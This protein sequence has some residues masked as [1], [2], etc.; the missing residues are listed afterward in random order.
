MSPNDQLTA[1]YPAY[2]RQLIGRSTAVAVAAYVL[3]LG[4]T[5]N[6]VVLARIQQFSLFL[7]T[8][9]VAGWLFV[10]WRQRD[11]LPCSSLDPA[12]FGWGVAFAVSGGANISGRVLVGVWWALLYLGVWWVLSDLRRRGMPGRWITD[13]V[14]IAL[15]P[16]LLLAVV[17]VALW[18]PAWWCLDTV[19][20]AFIPPRP[21]GTLGNANALG[22]V[23]AM[24][25]PLALVRVR[26]SWRRM[27]RRLWAVWVAVASMGLLLTFS[28]GA[29]LATLAGLITFGGLM[30]FSQGLNSVA[31]WRTLSLMAC[32]RIAVG[33]VVVSTCVLLV[34]TFSL[35][36]FDTPRRETSTRLALLGVAWDM[37]LEHPLAGT[38]PF[39]FGRF[40]LAE[41]SFPP[42][43]PHAHAH[44]LILNIAGELG[45][46]GLVALLCTV[47][48]I[49]W[50]GWR[51]MGRTSDPAER[52]HL[53][54]CGAA[55]VA[56]LVH[57]MVEMPLLQP[58]VMLL[59]L[60]I[61]AAVCEKSDGN[62]NQVLCSRRTTA[63]RI[64]VLA[65][66]TVVLATGWWSARV[67]AT[68]ERG[69]RALGA[70][71]HDRALDLLKKAADSWPDVAL[72]H[73]EYGYA[74]GVAVAHGEDHC[75]AEG[76]A[77][78][79]RALDEEP[80][81]A[82]WW[83][84]LAVL[85]WEAD[86]AEAAIRAL[87]HAT[88]HAP[89]S[90][91]LW[92]N[93]GIFAEAAG[94]EALAVTAYERALDADPVWDTA[95]RFWDQTPLR[96]MVAQR[97]TGDLAPLSQVALYMAAGDLAGA[98]AV[99]EAE[100]DR[101][102]SQPWPYVSIARVHIAVGDYHRA[103]AYL[104]A[105]RVLVHTP[106]G[107]AW[108]KVGEAQLAQAQGDKAA[109]VALMKDA[110]D[111]M[112]PDGT[113]H[114]LSYGNDIAYLQFLRMRVPGVLLPQ[115]TVY[116]TEP[117]LIELLQADYS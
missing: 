57:H 79:E 23:I 92:L 15:I 109:Y 69:Q 34:L 66:C 65:V 86:Q 106:E 115:L 46:L 31:W 38:G 14:L 3:A 45:L 9:G 68:Y 7:L 56:V 74:C 76:I 28:R 91:D 73:A 61:V 52:A 49:A 98:I 101:D 41:R 105:A 39:T 12:L 112:W 42:D 37:F 54:A 48:L 93:L 50:H 24:A 95:M 83:A 114:L 20:V 19:R 36:V 1:D 27:D 5:F 96:Q 8:V 25:L 64:A 51:G 16:V 100:I 43:Q 99:L 29:W 82:V 116:G 113:G 104:D 18:F 26:W 72:Y 53:A 60:G 21:P 108:I 44:N 63:Y 75:L 10:V 70:G 47:M 107:K 59:L 13:G 117:A 89:E 111:V 97:Y 17:Q 78:Y 90:P 102:P 6:G 80:E 58:A 103:R 67:Y 85:L 22:S 88:A 110:R 32:R 33:M 40:W 35:S 4:G 81:N 30:Y 71:D 55:L 11:V 94:Q 77:A 2:V 84:N 87:Q 62:T